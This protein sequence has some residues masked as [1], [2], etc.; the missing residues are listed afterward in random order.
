M[1]GV[2]FVTSSEMKELSKTVINDFH[3]LLPTYPEIDRVGWGQGVWVGEIQICR[4]LRLERQVRI[5]FLRAWRQG[6]R[7]QRAYIDPQPLPLT[8]QTRLFERMHTDLHT[9]EPATHWLAPPAWPKWTT[10]QDEIRNQ[11]VFWYQVVLWQRLRYNGE[12]LDKSC[13]SF[14]FFFG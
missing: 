9:N 6:E 7:F 12:H 5:L 14:F 10:K 2:S 1:A 3:I 4:W 13:F 11:T 8:K